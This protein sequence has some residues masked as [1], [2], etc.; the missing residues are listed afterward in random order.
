MPSSNCE[1]HAC[2]VF[3]Q[4]TIRQH[5]TLSR[6][7]RT[8]CHIRPILIRSVIRNTDIVFPFDECEICNLVPILSIIEPDFAQIGFGEKAMLFNLKFYSVRF[9]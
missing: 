9:R 5:L 1:L 2:S 7:I 6:S 8:G 4:R 3:W